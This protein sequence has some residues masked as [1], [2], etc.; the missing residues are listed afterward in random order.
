[1]A[2]APP[3]PA[4][5]LELVQRSAAP[6]VRVAA[7]ELKV[8]GVELFT[9]TEPPAP[10]DEDSEVKLT[11]VVAGKPVDGR[12]LMRAVLDARP[13][14]KTIAKLALAVAQR[15]GDILDA[16]TTP[17]QRKARV[18]PPALA[19]NALTFWVWT[20]DVPRSLERGT[21]DL[22]TG[23]VEIAP[24]AMP[25]DAMIAHAIA[26]LGGVSVLRHPAAI[27]TLADACSDPRARQ[28]LVSALASHPR[29]R[30]R[31]AVADQI[32]RC[33]AAAVDPLIAAMEQDKAAMVRSQAALALGRVGEPRARPSLAKA[34]RSEDANLAWAAKNSLGKIK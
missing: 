32:H 25:R 6:N 27:R 4:T 23:A 18:R 31:V 5:P 7:A 15:E 13:D 28:A 34:A 14:R 16:A 20:T 21:V 3:K 22:A 29:P 19:R 17:E 8:P 26:T 33:G 2:P 11:G 24:P 12:D 9:L 30:T 10:G 1:M